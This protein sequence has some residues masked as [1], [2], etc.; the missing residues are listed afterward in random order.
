MFWGSS[1]AT[2]GE[3]KKMNSKIQLKLIRFVPCL[4]A[5]GLSLMMFIDAMNAKLLTWEVSVA[6]LVITWLLVFK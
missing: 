1:Q 4:K 3:L 2:T 6:E 5:R